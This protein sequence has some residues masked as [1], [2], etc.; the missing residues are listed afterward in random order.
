MASAVEDVASR[1]SP[2]SDIDAWAGIGGYLPLRP[3]SKRIMS[4]SR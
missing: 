1:T 3:D 2:P 4:G